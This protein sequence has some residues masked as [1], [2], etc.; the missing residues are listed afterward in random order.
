[1]VKIRS[2]SISHT[3]PDGQEVMLHYTCMPWESDT[4]ANAYTR[5]GT[6]IIDCVEFTQEFIDE[7]YDSFMETIL[8][9]ETKSA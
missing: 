7:N 9:H 6:V 3:L 5:I 2:C 8:N 4:Y 1:M